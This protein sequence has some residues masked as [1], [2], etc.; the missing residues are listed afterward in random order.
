[1]ILKSKF[2]V[3]EQVYYF[4]NKTIKALKGE[5]QAIYVS[6]TDKEISFSY[7]VK[8]LGSFIVNPFAT[9]LPESLIFREKDDI[10]DFCIKLTDNI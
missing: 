5:I 7:F 1:M 6:A 8:P 10:I 2:D 4:D 3:G 9:T